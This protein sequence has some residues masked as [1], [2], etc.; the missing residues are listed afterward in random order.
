M[1]AASAGLAAEAQVVRPPATSVGF[2]IYG[3][4]AQW[5][6]KLHRLAHEPIS[7]QDNNRAAPAAPRAAGDG[8]L[9]QGIIAQPD[10]A[11]LRPSDPERHRDGSG[12]GPGCGSQRRNCGRHCSRDY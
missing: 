8:V 6:V 3:L 4:I 1:A 12:V 5:F 9:M 11:R 10:T 2:L 7:S